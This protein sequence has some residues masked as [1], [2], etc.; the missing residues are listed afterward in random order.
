MKSIS[1]GMNLI[2]LLTGVSS[3]MGALA[4]I[5]MVG[6]GSPEQ[7]F[8]AVLLVF[9]GV[10]LVTQSYVNF[11]HLRR[12]IGFRV[13]SWTTNILATLAI[14]GIVLSEI[15]ANGPDVPLFGLAL[16]VC[17]LSFSMTW[18]AL[19]KAEVARR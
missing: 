9:L 12:K 6:F 15:R 14:G 17:V 18:L 11:V 10:M 19:R 2:C 3:L 8:S 4:L 1:Y 16:A 13:S 7:K 5:N